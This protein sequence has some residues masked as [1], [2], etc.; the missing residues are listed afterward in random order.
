M[1]EGTIDDMLAY[2][3][4]WVQAYFKG[5]RARSI[6]PQNAAAAR[7]DSSGK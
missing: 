5:K 6:V 4:P 7:H 1:V 3:D 2:D